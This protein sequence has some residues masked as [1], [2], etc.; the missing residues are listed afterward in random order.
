[1]KTDQEE[2]VRFNKS[3]RL[4]PSQRG[5]VIDPNFWFAVVAFAFG[6]YVLVRIPGYDVGYGY[7]YAAVVVLAM[8][9][10]AA[11]CV[12]RLLVV[13]RGVITT[14]TGFTHDV[15]Y[16]KTPLRP[17]PIL[18]YASKSR[19][20]HPLRRITFNGRTMQIH[21]DVHSKF[22]PEH[23][24]TIYLTPNGKVIVNVIPT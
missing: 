14:F 7:A 8:A 4:H 18:L 2:V 10:L 13:R 3:G 5:R 20:G 15:G 17:Y 19:G 6:I 21:A 9:A 11:F 16:G 22:R 24:N 12:G 23:E 1:M